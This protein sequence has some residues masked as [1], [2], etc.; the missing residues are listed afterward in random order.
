MIDQ[1]DIPKH[2][3]EGKRLPFPLYCP[4]LLYRS[5]MTMCWH[6]DPSQRPSFA[7]LA[8]TIRQILRQ[9]DMDQQRQQSSSA[10][11][12]D[13]TIIQY[14]PMNGKSERSST[15][16]LSST[17]TNSI[18]R[19]AKKKSDLPIHSRADVFTAIR[20]LNLPDGSDTSVAR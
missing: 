10:D 3:K 5:V 17:T 4:A 11:D 6:A 2:V 12:D 14:Y 9:L 7:Q 16:S 13:T 20:L 15:T 1:A 18:D 8:H 19:P